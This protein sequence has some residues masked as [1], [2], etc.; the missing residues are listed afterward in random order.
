D[1]NSEE[2][3]TTPLGKSTDAVSPQ[4]PGKQNVTIGEGNATEGGDTDDDKLSGSQSVSASWKDEGFFSGRTGIIALSIA[5]V[6]ILLVL[7]ILMSFCWRRDRGGGQKSGAA[8]DNIDRC[9]CTTTET[10]HDHA[11]KVKCMKDE[12]SSLPPNVG[13]RKKKVSKSGSAEAPSRSSEKPVDFNARCPIRIMVEMNN[14][15][16][17]M[18]HLTHGA[19][20]NES[21]TLAHHATQ[22]PASLPHT[23]MTTPSSPRCGPK[24]HGSSSE[25]PNLRSNSHHPS[26][27]VLPPQCLAA[28]AQHP[29]THPPLPAALAKK[30]CPH[31]GLGGHYEDKCPVI[32]GLPLNSQLPLMA[33]IQAIAQCGFCHH[34]ATLT[35]SVMDHVDIV[36]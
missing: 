3:T 27:L 13:A 28:A 26:A 7:V 9:T 16:L 5:I 17:Q 2:T 4:T 35:H 21:L 23:V 25:S 30:W 1:I 18:A 8:G 20:D 24:Q 31:H 15:H 11:N 6:L 36:E 22:H 14:A 33:A 10:T 12:T 19:F 29:A 34:S 32:K